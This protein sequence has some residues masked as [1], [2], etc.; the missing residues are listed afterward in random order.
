V[1]NR[2]FHF[3]FYFFTAAAT[4]VLPLLF[5]LHRKLEGIAFDSDR[6]FIVTGA[7]AEIDGAV[8]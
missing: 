8:C 6:C 1:R 2:S 3:F 7:V 5:L 4:P